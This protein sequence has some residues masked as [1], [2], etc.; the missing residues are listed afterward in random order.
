MQSFASIQASAIQRHGRKALQAR[1]SGGPDVTALRA[2]PDDRFLAQ[3][4][5][6]IFQAGF[7]WQLIENKWSGFEEAFAGFNPAFWAQVPDERL[8]Q[9]A[10]DRR[11]VRNFVKI[12]TVRANAAMIVQASSDTG[13]FGAFLANWPSD[14]QVGLLG[15]LKNSGERLGGMTAQYFLRFV[16]WDGFILSRDVEAALIRAEVIERSSAAKSTRARIQAAFNQWHS[17]SGLPYCDLSRVL[18]LSI[19]G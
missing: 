17:E 1:L 7:V 13:G 6:S 5:K 8:E 12:R 2:L 9:L 11:I 19:D 3:M 4:T 18:A 10:S 16:G 15:W 14:D